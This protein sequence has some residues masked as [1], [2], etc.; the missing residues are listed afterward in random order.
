MM[1][2]S[3][4]FDQTICCLR[5]LSCAEVAW[6]LDWKFRYRRKFWI[7]VT[8]H[9][10]ADEGAGGGIIDSAT[11]IA[12]LISFLPL[13][14]KNWIITSLYSSGFHANPPHYKTLSL[15]LYYYYIHKHTPQISFKRLQG[16]FK[17]ISLFYLWY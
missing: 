16:T 9:T 2:E 4:F 15:L 6:L 17:C 11:N 10:I 14:E 13:Y 7:A 12:H 1:Q 5:L 3:F 8:S